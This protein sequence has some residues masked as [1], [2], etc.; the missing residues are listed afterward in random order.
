MVSKISFNLVKNY[1]KP[2]EDAWSDD[3]WGIWPIDKKE[4]II[5]RPLKIPTTHKTLQPWHKVLEEDNIDLEIVNGKELTN[6]QHSFGSQHQ[7]LH[8]KRQHRNPLLQK[9]RMGRQLSFLEHSYYR[10]NILP[11][12]L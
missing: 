12:F 11:N 1:E 10:Q 2:E 5:H 8:I 9:L 4:K 3:Y 7:T 6:N